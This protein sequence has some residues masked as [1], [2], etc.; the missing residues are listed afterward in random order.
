MLE[1]VEVMRRVLVVMRLVL[2][3]MRRVLEVM[4]RVLEVMRRVL[5]VMR[6]V[7]RCMLE[8]VEGELCLLEVLEMPEVMYCVLRRLL[9]VMCCVLGTLYTGGCG[10]MTR[11]S[12]LCQHRYF[13]FH[14]CTDYPLRNCPICSHFVLF[15][16]SC[17]I[18]PLSRRLVTGAFASPPN[19]VRNNRR[20]FP[21]YRLCRWC[22]RRRR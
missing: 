14:N 17:A 3:V 16:Y 9:E 1:V 15:R 10:V 5:E 18:I 2:E 11:T 7:L 8:A 22:R 4:R 6:Q 19:L 21:F 13:S 12:S 20:G